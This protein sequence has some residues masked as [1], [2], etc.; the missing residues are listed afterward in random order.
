MYED[1]DG[2]LVMAATGPLRSIKVCKAEC[3]GWDLIVQ[4]T[5]SCEQDPSKGSHAHIRDAGIDVQHTIALSAHQFEVIIPSTLCLDTYSTKVMNAH[6]QTLQHFTS[7]NALRGTLST[8][9]Y[10]I[11]ITLPTSKFD[12]R[13]LNNSMLTFLRE[14][15][16]VTFG[17]LNSS[18]IH[19]SGANAGLK[20]LFNNYNPSTFELISLVNEPPSAIFTSLSSDKAKHQV[21]AQACLISLIRAMTTG[22]DAE[23]SPVSVLASVFCTNANSQ[24][25]SPLAGSPIRRSP[26]PPPASPKAAS[27][28]PKSPA[29]SIHHADAAKQRS[30]SPR[31][32]V[33][34]TSDHTGMDLSSRAYT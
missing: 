11:T 28:L 18:L 14:T 6:A 33:P 9:D 29:Q 16:G 21:L 31:R 17:F 25:A 7:T 30:P 34:A 27:P 23:Q 13:L 5:V 1:K 19:A 8:L 4:A 22:A 26:T 24:P 10:T 32:R 12:P 20:S 2:R 3:E 15:P